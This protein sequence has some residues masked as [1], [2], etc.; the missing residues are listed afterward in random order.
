MVKLDRVSV[1]L[2]WWLGGGTFGRRLE[3]RGKL[4]D[5][6]GLAKER[7]WWLRICIGLCLPLTF[8]SLEGEGFEHFL[9]ARW[10]V[11]R[12]NVADEDDV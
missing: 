6:G 1:R 11:E 3:R 4:L 12:H 10:E 9:G 8:S 7:G 2:G 5:I